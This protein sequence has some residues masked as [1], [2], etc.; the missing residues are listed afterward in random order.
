MNILIVAA[1]PDDEILGVGG[2]IAKHVEAGDNVYA[3]IL[4]E[5]Q[6]SRFDKREDAG[7]EILEELHGDTMRSAAVLGMKAVYFENFADNRFDSVDLLEIVKAVER[8]VK[9]LQP[10]VIYTHHKGDLNVDHQMTYK[11]VLTATR[12]MT[13]Q[14]VKEIYTFETVSSTEWNFTY[15]DMQ[16]APNVFVKLTDEQFGKKLTAMEKYRSELCEYPH[17]RSLE[18]LKAVAKRW[19]GVVGGHYVEAFETVRIVR[20]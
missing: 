4:G 13:G 2:T 8:R 5:G 16:F 12:P 19:G 9:E 15:G 6:T 11:A 10:A 14:P 17:P 18:M 7:T 1:H 3:L 20:E